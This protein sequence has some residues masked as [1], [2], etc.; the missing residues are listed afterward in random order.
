MFVIGVCL[1]VVGC[2]VYR[3]ERQQEQER[4]QLC[5]SEPPRWR[6]D[7]VL[8]RGGAALFCCAGLLL[9]CLAGEEA[10]RIWS[11]ELQVI[12]LGVTL[13]VVGTAVY[14]L[15][16]R[17]AQR[18]RQAGMPPRSVW[19]WIVRVLAYLFLAAGICLAYLGVVPSLGP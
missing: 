13:I 6:L 19:S 4:L 2:A 8:A 14:H 10:R 1:L 9:L 16:Y 5:L 15:E 7:G 11:T 17:W 3:Y 12:T 18:R